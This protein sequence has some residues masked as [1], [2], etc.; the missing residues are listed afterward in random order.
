MPFSIGF[1]RAQGAWGIKWRVVRAI[2]G[3]LGAL[4]T[5]VLQRFLQGP[6]RVPRLAQGG[7]GNLR[8]WFREADSTRNARSGGP[9]ALC[10]FGWAYGQGRWDRWGACVLQRILEVSVEERVGKIR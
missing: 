8:R 7:V 1:Y 5:C 2:S 10:G 9:G 3:M 4:G 6:K